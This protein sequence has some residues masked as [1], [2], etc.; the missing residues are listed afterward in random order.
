MKNGYGRGYYGEGQL[1][2]PPARPRG[3]RWTKW[4]L[5]VGVV[6]AGAVIWFMWPRK[7]E[8]EGSGEDGPRSIPLPPGQTVLPSAQLAPVP[9]APQLSTSCF[10]PGA[11]GRFSHGSEGRNYYHGAEERNYSHG[12]E[13]GF[14]YGPEGRGFSPSPEGRGFSHG[15]EGRG[16]HGGEGRGFHG[17]EARGFHGGE[18]RGFH[19]G[20]ARGHPSQRAYEDAVVASARQLQATGVKVV[21]APHLAHLARRIGP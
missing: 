1:A 4:A 10:F 9:P 16:F 6:G 2:Q 17:G 12:T 8:N 3:S 19:G 18:A 20:E 11:E 15:G 13:G 21:L 5:A 7:S 14:S